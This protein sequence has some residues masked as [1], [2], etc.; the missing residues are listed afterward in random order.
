[1]NILAS[2]ILKFTRFVNGD[3]D[4]NNPDRLKLYYNE[5]DA[6]FIFLHILEDLGY[7]RVFHADFL[8]MNETLDM[9]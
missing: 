6:F 3:I 5:L 8:T 1:M 7:S 9:F 2:W 4:P